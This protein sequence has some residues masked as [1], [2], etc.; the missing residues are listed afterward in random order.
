[1]VAQIDTA[2]RGEDGAGLALQPAEQRLPDPVLGFVRGEGAGAVTAVFNLSGAPVRIKA[3]PGRAVGPVLA[4]T[5]E[6]D[7]LE[8][9]PNGCIWLAAGAD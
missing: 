3:P 5:V 2:R 6:G 8:L 7:M 4:A 1:M 9:G